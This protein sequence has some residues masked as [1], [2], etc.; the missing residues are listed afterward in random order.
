MSVVASTAEKADWF[1]ISEAILRVGN[2]SSLDS[3][4]AQALTAWLEKLDPD[5]RL[6]VAVDLYTT[7]EVSVGRAA[8][9]AGLNY[10]VFE[11]K[12]KE[13]RIAFIEADVATEEEAKRQ[14]ELIHASF[15]LP[16][17]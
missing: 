6:K 11:R 13:N 15:S 10:F 14:E 3:L 7:E 1:V 12:L 2:I 17:P 4:L 8:E 9:I 5:L 16:N